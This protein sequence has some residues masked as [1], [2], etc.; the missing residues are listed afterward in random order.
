MT[1]RS[2]IQEIALEHERY[3]GYRRVAAEL[4]RRGMMVNHKRVARIMRTDNLLTK[5][6]N[7]TVK[8]KWRERYP[9]KSYPSCGADERL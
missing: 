1:V 2:A 4:R 5:E 7:C 9:Q 6:R 8:G 3:Y